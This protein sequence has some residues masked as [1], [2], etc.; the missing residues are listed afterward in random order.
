MTSLQISCTQ[1]TTNQ[2]FPEKCMDQIIWDVYVEC[3]T[4][5]HA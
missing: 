4:Q 3:Y 5:T 2:S 1:V